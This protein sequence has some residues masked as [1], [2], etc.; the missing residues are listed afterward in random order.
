MQT[1][2]ELQHY[3]SQLKDVP[4]HYKIAVGSLIFTPE[5]KVILLERGKEAR[6][7]VGKLEG[8]GG[9]IHENET[10]LHEA[11]LR[12]IHEEIGDVS[13]EVDP[14][15]TVSILPGEKHPYWVIVDYL[16]R[17]TGGTPEVKE[18][19]KINRI[20]YLDLS[21]IDDSKLS[22]YQQKT[23]QAYREKYGTTPYYKYH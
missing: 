9:G 7:S 21:A 19:R 2:D 12:E 14:L 22:I 23:M 10:N 13:V 6:D 11:L 1:L 20:V 8:V 4:S 3:L 17:L 16:C 5:D 15:L 18:P